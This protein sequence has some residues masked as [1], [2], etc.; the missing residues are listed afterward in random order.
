MSASLPFIFPLYLL[1]LLPFVSWLPYML[2]GFLPSCFSFLSSPAP[3]QPHSCWFFLF[4]FCSLL[5]HMRLLLWNHTYGITSVTL[6]YR[7]E[8]VGSVVCLC[9]RAC[10]IKCSF[11]A[12]CTSAGISGD[13]WLIFIAGSIALGAGFSFSSTSFF[14]SASKTS[15]GALEMLCGRALALGAT[16]L[17]FQQGQHNFQKT[18]RETT[19]K[20][21]PQKLTTTANR[22][23]ETSGK[24][25]ITERNVSRHHK[26]EAQMVIW[27]EMYQLD[28]GNTCASYPSIPQR[29]QDFAS[30]GG[31]LASCHKAR[32]LNSEAVYNRNDCFL[33]YLTISFPCLCREHH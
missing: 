21:R 15:V 6:P 13:V 5:L 2:I 27:M 33:F 4:L 32:K 18:K 31:Y 7:D 22:L 25:I 3:P 10:L 30:E 9:T 16:S 1:C 14:S 12:V 29:I 28:S 20:A 23:T 8:D 17:L 11:K 26:W 19:N 24:K